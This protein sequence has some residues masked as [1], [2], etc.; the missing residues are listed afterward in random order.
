[1]T[2][3]ADI[4]IY[5]QTLNIFL[6]TQSPMILKPIM[7]HKSLKIDKVYINNDPGLALISQCINGNPGLTLAYFTAR[8]SL[9]KFAYCEYRTNS[10]VSVY[11]TIGPLVSYFALKYRLWILVRA[12]LL[13]RF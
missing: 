2:K 3:M 13:G 11:K 5:S 6:R 7:Q 12:P 9:V 10:Q 8:S 4:P 1:M